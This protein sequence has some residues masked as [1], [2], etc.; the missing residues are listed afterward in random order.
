MILKL[1]ATATPETVDG[2]L[3]Q[4]EEAG[5]KGQMVQHFNDRLI[6]IDG[7]QFHQIKAVIDNRA[8]KSVHPIGQGYKLVSRKFKPNDSVIPVGNRLIG[9]GHVTLIA[10]PCAVESETQIMTIAKAVSENGAAIL[11][12]GVFKPRTSPYAFQG[13]GQ[14]GLKYLVEAGR[15]YNL[16]VVTEVLDERDF[17]LVAT[18]VDLIQIGARN[19]QNFALLKKAGSCQKPIMLKRG[20]SATIEE[21]LLAAEYIIAHGNP[22]V[23]LCE[24]GIKT[25]EPMTRNT[26]DI[27]C[28]PLIKRLSHLPILVDPSHAAG[29]RGLIKDLSMAAIAAGADGV[30]IEAHNDPDNALS[31]GKQSVL[32]QVLSGILE[33]MCQVKKVLSA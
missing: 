6:C 32:P 9:G 30:M 31:D 3:K 33:T 7:G 27:S 4:L 10:G 15:L 21:F 23:I 8:V 24:R 20:P 11:R 19:M 16:P 14:E 13:L 1:R 22:H 12:G 17:D 2:M 29:D 18:H 5:V 28:V 26:L 25:Y